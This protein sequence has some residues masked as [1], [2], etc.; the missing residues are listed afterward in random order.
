MFARAGVIVAIVLLM[1]LAAWLIYFATERFLAAKTAGPQADIAATSDP[2]HRESVESADYITI[3]S[4]QDTSTLDTAGR[5]RAEIVSQSNIE[6]IRLVSLRP[7]DKRND[8]A[9]PIVLTL[10][11]GV[12]SQISGKRVT[13]EIL[14]KS[15]SSGPVGFAV[16][17]EFDNE[18]LCGRKRFRIGIQPEAIVFTVNTRKS[19]NEN[20]KAFMTI[21]TDITS[22]AS[23]TG[24]GDPVDILYARLRVPKE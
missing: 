3:L 8:P 4:P 17:C 13:V 23:L 16:G 2:A 6:M 14:A 11:P 7:E 21:S 22:S 15:G 18:D 12:L 5:G 20:S 1:A 10:S 19:L 24:E 9:P